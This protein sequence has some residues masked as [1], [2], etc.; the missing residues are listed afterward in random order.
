M[1]FPV[2]IQIGST[3]ILLHAVTETLGIF[4]GFRYFLYLRKKQGDSIQAEKRTW[5]IIGALFGAIMGSRLLGGFENPP[6]LFNTNNPW[7]YLYENKTV[8]GGFLGGLFGVELTKR[9]TAEKQN[10]GD[11]FT[12]PM[13]LA[14]IIGRLGCF[15][16]GIHE[17]TY[18]NVTKLF[19]GL[20]LG[21]GL[22]R[23]PAALY[24]IIFLVLLWIFLRILNKKYQFAQ[25]AIFK[26]FMIAY[27]LFR[28]LLDFIK[29][30]YTFSMGLSSIQIICLVGIAYYYRYIIHPQK[31]LTQHA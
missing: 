24:E 26:I 8:V 2:Y 12:Y 23:H 4:V 28:F 11:L 18:G 1:E 25:G 22:S 10:S 31:L 27:L 20:D 7:L 16:M 5:I 29:P 9:I 21:D 14:L 13:I 17:E 19:T 15:S 30:H 6:A 3:K